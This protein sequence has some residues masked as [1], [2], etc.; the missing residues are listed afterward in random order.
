GDRNVERQMMSSELQNPR[1]LFRR[2]SED[3]NVIEIFTEHQAAA[4][5]ATPARRGTAAA[6]ALWAIRSIGL[7][8]FVAIHDYLNLL[9]AA[10]AERGGH[11]R[12]GCGTLGGRH[13]FHAEAIA[14]D[15]RNGQIRPALTLLFVIE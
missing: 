15:D 8:S 7:E 4:R 6:T 11:Q 14:G 9:E 2:G 3:G 10:F 12:H 5:S 1:G 13:F